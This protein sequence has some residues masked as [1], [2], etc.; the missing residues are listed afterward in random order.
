MID[1]S[2]ELRLIKSLDQDDTWLNLIYIQI[3]PILY[4]IRVI[5]GKWTDL[6]TFFFL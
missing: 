3:M 6:K 4:F 5:I 2:E 1:T